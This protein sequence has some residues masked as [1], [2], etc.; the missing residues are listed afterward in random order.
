[1]VSLSNTQSGPAIAV[2]IS[3]CLAFFVFGIASFTK[4]DIYEKIMVRRGTASLKLAKRAETRN[5]VTDIVTD[6]QS[7]EPIIVDESITEAEAVVATIEEVR[8]ESRRTNSVPT[9]VDSRS[10]SLFA[11][12]IDQEQF[13]CLCRWATHRELP[14][15]SR[16][17]LNL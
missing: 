2:K 15:Q 14:F 12:N 5:L 1:M 4:I 13:P 11:M 3:C 7:Y 8:C 16:S 10:S 6:A 9:N 17:R